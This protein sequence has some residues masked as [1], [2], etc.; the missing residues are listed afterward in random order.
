LAECAFVDV[1]E[2]EEPVDHLEWRLTRHLFT[3]E[4]RMFS[5]ADILST[6]FS[7]EEGRER[8]KHLALTSSM[9]RKE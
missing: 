5:F 6:T 8:N 2:D 7:R 1:D 3:S 4:K 9:E